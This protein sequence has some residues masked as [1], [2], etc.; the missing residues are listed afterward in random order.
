VIP[1]ISVLGALVFL[2]ATAV[3]P[4]ELGAIGTF[5][6]FHRDGTFVVELVVDR[7]HLPLFFGEDRPEN[8]AGTGPTDLHPRPNEPFRIEGLTPALDR[9]IGGILYAVVRGA[10]PAF[11]GRPVATRIK[12]ARTAGE[13]DASV[14]AAP[15]LRLILTG[16]IPP[17]A[18]AFTWSNTVHLGTYMLTVES[19]DQEYAERQWLESGKE[20]AP[21][22]LAESVIPPTRAQVVRTYLALGFT[23]ILPK[24]ADHILFV[25]GIFLLSTRPKPVLLQVTAFTVAHTITLALTIYGVVSLPRTIVEPLIALSI[26][27]VAIENVMT[28]ELRPWRIALVFGFGLL[29]GMGFAGVLTE[30]G[31]PRSEFV[32][33]LLSFNLGVEAGQLTVIGIALVLFGLPFRKKAWYRSR[34]VVPAS[35][36]IA[37]VGFYWSVERV[38][39]R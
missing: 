9:N 15:Q 14:A 30:L 10:R 16:T 25:L 29:H 34:I 35:I 5:V 17:G 11:D 2:T 8:I 1:R 24:G 38:L 21:F 23:H 12:L 3:L 39:I 7:E 26:V 13:S 19:E 18:R 32:P 31:L 27:Y 36:A 33:A 28:T 6:T 20:S 22:A 4:H 37:A